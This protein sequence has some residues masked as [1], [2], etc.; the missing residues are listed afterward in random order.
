[1]TDLASRIVAIPDFPKPGIVFRDIMPLLRDHFDA[2]VEAM[3]AQLSD[4]EWASIDVLIGIESRGFVFAAALAQRLG[5]GFVPVRKKGKLPPPVVAKS[6]QLEYGSDHLE[7]RPG[8]GRGV[9]VDDVLATGGTLATAGG[10]CSDAGYDV[11]P[12]AGAGR[13][14][15][16]RRLPLAG[17]RH[18]A[19]SCSTEPLPRTPMIRL[20]RRF[21]AFSLVALVAT[22]SLGVAPARA[23]DDPAVVRT[24]AYC[25]ALI[26]SMKSAKK[27]PVRKRYENLE[28]AIRTMFDLPAM[29]RLTVGPAWTTMSADDQQAIVDA[30]SRFTIA[31]YAFRFDGYSGEH[32]EV[33]PSPEVRGEN[34]LVRT[35]LV[36][37]SGDPVP[38][39]YLM[40]A[41][42]GGW[43]ATDV[44][45]NGT[46][47]ELATRRSEF[48]SLLR[49]G[50]PAA[51]IDRLK[52]QT[53]R[54]LGPT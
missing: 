51:L 23:A 6:Y 19:A 15:P 14:A 27:T 22:V 25:D 36:K 26:E 32:F 1:M 47:S 49:S 24:R 39:N 53:E 16:R 30:F 8:T 40:H 12:A 42:T 13:P 5:K 17:P 7:M 4:E 11:A 28:P 20:L 29:T 9:L 18:R 21:V 45:L 34:R 44:Y 31:T 2:T 38:L 37:A 48:A 50:G 10:L 43:K 46:I 54:Q 52:A 41:A 3:A 33:D 35:T